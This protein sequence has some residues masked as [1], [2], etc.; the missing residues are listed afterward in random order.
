MWR[1]I[2]YFFLI[3][4]I[5]IALSGCNSNE[6]E[7]E[8]NQVIRIGVFEWNQDSEQYLR[9]MYTDMY[10]L[11]NENVEF[12][13]VHSDS[14]DPISGLI[15]LMEGSNAPDIVLLNYAVI[16]SFIDKN[17]LIDLDPYFTK[18][19]YDLTT[20]AA[21]VIDTL[22]T[23][24]NGKVYALTPK[25]NSSALIYNKNIFQKAN[26]SLPHDQMTWDQ[27]F[28]VAREIKQ[29]TKDDNIYGFSFSWSWMQDL[30]EGLNY[31]YLSPLN[32]KLFNDQISDMNVNNERVLRFW[33]T[34]NGLYQDRIIPRKEDSEKM[35]S[36]KDNKFGENAFLS[37]QIAMVPINS[38]VLYTMLTNLKASGQTLSFE[39]D[40]ASLP[41]HPEA[42]NMGA[43]IGMEPLFA[44][45]SK[46]NNQEAAWKFIE[47][48]N[49]DNWA[50]FYSDRTEDL[51][52]EFKY[53]TNTSVYNKDYNIGAFYQLSAPL[54]N[55]DYAKTF[56]QYPNMKYIPE[57]GS[58]YF[59]KML[60]GNLTPQ[61]ALAKWNDNG[62]VLLKRIKNNPGDQMDIN[63]MEFEQ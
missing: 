36:N 58:F 6:K 52:T 16:P 62:N 20:K 31:Y 59:N 8:Q 57:M 41:V 19:R 25:F 29:K 15:S 1:R 34:V 17:L 50:S 55:L 42:P 44:I 23:F 51:L 54:I 10:E 4:C 35:I 49:S 2:L 12:E 5:V 37:G 60:E 30:Y 43:Q 48:V 7:E 14:K 32:M 46:S 38:R 40:I 18:D 63:F 33:N 13:F 45:N 21:N 28:E 11:E 24:G 47:F 22:R 56:L 9:D 27:A 53:N 26:V 3:S 61:E 39:W